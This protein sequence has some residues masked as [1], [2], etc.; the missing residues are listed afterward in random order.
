[1]TE[2]IITK[3]IGGFYYVAS[4]QGMVEC[5]ARGRLRRE[6]IT[7]LV[8][9][10]AHV[11]VVSQNPLQGVVEKILPRKNALVRPP[12]ANVDTVVAVIAAASPLPDFYMIDK[13]IV[14]AE[15]A[16]IGVIVVVNKTDLANGEDILRIYGDAGYQVVSLCAA[17]GDG[18][19]ELKN[20]IGGK[21]TAFAGNSGVGKSS[22]LNRLGHRLETGGVS[23]IERGRHT[24]RHC[25]L[26]PLDGG[27][28]VIDT[29]GFSI[30]EVGGISEDALKDYFIE[31]S[32][33]EDCRFS[34]CLH[35]G[36]KPKDCGVCA[37]VSDGKISETRYNSYLGIYRAI[38]ES[39]EW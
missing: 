12:V 19:E 29:P 31:F 2:G 18:V 26:L 32:Q 16:G 14:S 4:G 34:G 24:T 9:D 5:R 3:G 1:M 25:E 30:L 33:H 17:R 11:S 13:L 28:Y 22:I 27:G 36:A 20:L 10:R 35:V 38:K 8:G 7:P 6:K 21:V 15:R 23:K 39:K 37:A